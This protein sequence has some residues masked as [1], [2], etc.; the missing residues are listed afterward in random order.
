MK[1]HLL[2]AAARGCA[3]SKRTKVFWFFFSKKNILALLLFTSPASAADPDVL[4]KLVDGKCV[5]AQLAGQPPRPCAA[6]D[7]ARR[8][9]LLKDLVGVAQYLAIPTV[10]VTGIEDP[11]VLDDASSLAVGWEARALVEAKLGR[12]LPRDGVSLTVNAVSARTQ[13]Q[14]HVHVDCLDESVRA[15]LRGI[16]LGESWGP[17]PAR[18]MGNGYI[19]RRLAGEAVTGNPYRMLAEHVGGPIGHWSLA[20]VG[21]TMPDGGPGFLLL[22]TEGARAHAEELQDHTCRGY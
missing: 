16:T 21:A 17:V 22:A 20:V 18:L 1:T 7:L 5:P 14:L 10:R 3:P 12:P 2:G 13:N 15:T 9:A 6:V 19:G 4:W 8:V 11:A